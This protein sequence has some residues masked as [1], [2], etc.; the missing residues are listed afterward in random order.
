MKT[1]TVDSVERFS[2]VCVCVFCR[3]WAPDAN[4]T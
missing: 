4:R 1:V 3:K 2:G